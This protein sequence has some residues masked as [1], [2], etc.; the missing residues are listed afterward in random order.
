MGAVLGRPVD[1]A[2]PEVVEPS[3]SVGSYAFLGG[4]IAELPGRTADTLVGAADRTRDRHRRAVGREDTAEAEVLHL[5]A[6]DVVFGGEAVTEPGVRVRDVTEG[7]GRIA[8]GLLDTD[9]RVLASCGHNW[10]SS[11][12]QYFHVWVPDGRYTICAGMPCFLSFV[13]NACE[14]RR[15]RISRPMPA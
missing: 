6:C 11:N 10:C 2:V 8:L 12:S 9:P 3:A 13:A 7:T 14:V 15:E 4:R 1:R 5:A